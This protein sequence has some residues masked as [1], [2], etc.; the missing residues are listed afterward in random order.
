M[1]LF[2]LLTCFVLVA[3]GLAIYFVKT[4]HGEK[5]PIG[6]LWLAFGFGSLAAIAA[7][8]IESFLLPTPQQA[9]TESLSSLLLVA[10]AIG[11]IEELVKFVPFALFIKNKRYFNENTDG[12]IYFALVGLGFGLP[13]NILYTLHYGVSTGVGRLVITPL[14]HA[15]ITGVVGY[16]FI[17]YKLGGGS[18]WR[19]IA[20]LAVAVLLHGLYD[21]GLTSSVMIYTI[22][23]I[24][25]TFGLTVALFG[26]YWH[27]RDLDERA[28]LSSVGHNDYCRSCGQRNSKHNLY[29]TQCGQRA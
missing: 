3:A 14:F 12:I 13:E 6:A 7:G 21:F 5:E 23:S 27:A 26:L 15:A 8:V 4:D 20:A 22:V 24:C 10:L 17:R 29:C 25:I 2:L 28:G 19:V 9:A 1:A 18:I 16:F 11:L